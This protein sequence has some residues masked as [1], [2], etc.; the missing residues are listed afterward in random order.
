M[1]ALILLKLWRAFAVRVHICDDSFK[2]FHRIGV[3][4]P[5]KRLIWQIRGSRSQFTLVLVSA[6]TLWLWFPAGGTFWFRPARTETP[7]RLSSSYYLIVT[8]YGFF[9]EAVSRFLPVVLKLNAKFSLVQRGIKFHSELLKGFHYF[10][11]N[12]KYINCVR[13]D[14]YFL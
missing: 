14:I 13:K 3:L 2:A 6:S 8:S 10:D 11:D 12:R 4:A 1:L 9:S 7:N 5:S